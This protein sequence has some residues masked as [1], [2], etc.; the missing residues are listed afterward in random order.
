MSEL[1]VSMSNQ[2]NGWLQFPFRAFCAF[3]VRTPFNALHAN[4]LRRLRSASE[5][6]LTGGILGA[7]RHPDGLDLPAKAAEIYTDVRLAEEEKE[8]RLDGGDILSRMPGNCASRRGRPC[9]AGTAHK[10]VLRNRRGPFLIR[11]LRCRA[12]L[13]PAQRADRLRDRLP[14]S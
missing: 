9:F 11:P 2:S 8:R 4:R 1:V 10:A 6:G 5:N 7:Y 12:V 14:Y 13:L 3:R